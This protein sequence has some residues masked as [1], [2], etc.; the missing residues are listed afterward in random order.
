[1]IKYKYY[2]KVHGTFTFPK[3]MRCVYKPKYLFTSYLS[4]WNDTAYLSAD[5]GINNYPNNVSGGS[6]ALYAAHY[7]EFAVPSTT[8]YHLDITVNLSSNYSSFSGKLLMSSTS[9]VVTDWNFTTSGSLVTYSTN[10]GVSY[11]KGCV[12]FVNTYG[13]ST[14]SYTLTIARS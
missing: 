14:T 3:F 4:N 6:I 7:R 12:M 13:P 9:G 1:M 5:Y 8:P 2:V 11:S 10:I